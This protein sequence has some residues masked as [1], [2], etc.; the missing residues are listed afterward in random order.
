MEEVPTQSNNVE[1]TEAE[2]P[3]A[4]AEEPVAAAEEPVAAAEEPVAAAEEPVAA[5]EEPV[6]AAE[7]PVRREKKR[8]EKKEKIIKRVKEILAQSPNKANKPTVI[9]I[10]HRGKKKRN[11][12][13]LEKKEETLDYSNRPND[14]Q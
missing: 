12:S 6:A 13:Q 1:K 9:I 10:C 5:A 3:V 4:A 14:S 7:E 8:D 2:E 11:P